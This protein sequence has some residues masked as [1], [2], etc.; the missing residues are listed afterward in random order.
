[1]LDSQRTGKTVKIFPT[2]EKLRENTGRCRRYPIEEAKA[3]T[4][5]AVFLEKIDE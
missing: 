1:M 3:D 4:F 2:L 5:L